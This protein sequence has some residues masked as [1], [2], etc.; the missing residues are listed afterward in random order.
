MPTWL[1]WLAL[2]IGLLA[3]VLV[4]STAITWIRSDRARLA[5]TVG[6]G[7]QEP[8]ANGDVTPVVFVTVEN[9]GPNPVRVL[10]FGSESAD[11]RTATW[12][13]ADALPP[14]ARTPVDVSSH[15][16]FTTRLPRSH[17]ESHFSN[18]RGRTRLLVQLASGQVARSKVLRPD[19]QREDASRSRPRQ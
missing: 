14:D 5:I 11:R 9:L 10:S 6:A 4:M 7:K 15:S 12:L 8:A 1:L 13:C 16:A 2:Y 17:F 18:G 19:S 3:C